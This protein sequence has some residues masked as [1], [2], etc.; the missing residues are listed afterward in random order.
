MS[1]LNLSSCPKYDFNPSW[2]KEKILGILWK[3][4]DNERV[5]MFK[6]KKKS[7]L[8][9]IV[10][11]LAVR[12]HSEKE[13]RNKLTLKEFEPEEIDEGIEMA[14]EQGL[15]LEPMKLAENVSDQLH[16]K[17]KGILYINQYLKSKGLPC[18]HPDWDME[19]EKAKELT[20]KRFNKNPPYTI[21]EKQ[22]IYR[23]LTNRGYADQTINQ[24]IHANGF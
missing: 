23:Y 24:V 1:T 11:Y 2:I 20:L 17:Q 3:M 19:L 7:A 10:D 22:D 13:I 9:K 15:M 8:E 12:D 14:Q 6:V 4:S 21:E 16:R 18:I 5:I